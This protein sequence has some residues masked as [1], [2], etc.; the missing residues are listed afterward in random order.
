MIPEFENYINTLNEMKAVEE[1]GQEEA[2]VAV[3]K[4]KEFIKDYR[5][6]PPEAIIS[7]EDNLIDIKSKE[8]FLTSRIL[9]IEEFTG[10]ELAYRDE[11]HYIF[12]YM[13]HM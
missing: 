10:F 7:I 5:V 4:L 9:E 6:C 12:R 11:T 1:R 13:D 8:R 2:N 3:D